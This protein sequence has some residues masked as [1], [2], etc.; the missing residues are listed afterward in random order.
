MARVKSIQDNDYIISVNN[1]RHL[2]DLGFKHDE[3]EEKYVYYFPALRHEK[4]TVLH[5]RIIA[6]IDTNKIQIDVIDNNATPYAPF[7]NIECGNY[8]TIMNKINKAIL[9]EFRK[10]K[11]VKGKDKTNES[12]HK[13][14]N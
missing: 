4:I 7:Y 3:T 12:Q 8:D 1:T 2:L 14:V 11:I 13:E 9:N 10:L 6:Y 5:G